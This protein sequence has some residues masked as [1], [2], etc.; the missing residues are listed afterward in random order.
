MEKLKQLIDEYGRWEPLRIYINRVETY[1]HSD[2]SVV[3]ENSKS[4]LDSIAREICEEKDIELVGTES[5]GSA[6][7]KAFRGIGYK[8]E[9][10][11]TQ[12]SSSIANI[13]QQ[14][15]NLRNEIGSTAHGKSMTELQNRNDGIDEITKIFLVDSTELTACFLIRA[16]ENE[17][18]RIVKSEISKIDY[19]ENEPFNEFWDSLYGEFEMGK[20]YT[21]PA[22]E[23]F[24]NVA[25]SAYEE[26]SK[27][28]QKVNL[29]E[30]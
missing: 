24:Y 12:L 1:F 7:K 29:D 14:M 11:E 20:D 9:T 4:I 17:N 23:V 27:E 13:G 6:I 19:D 8:G 22:S 15:G 26:E 25:Y 16:Y 30:E 21:Y 5:V 2:F 3:L 28:Y 10:L 18:P